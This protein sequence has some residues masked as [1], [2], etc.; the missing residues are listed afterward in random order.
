M[1][2]SEEIKEILLLNKPYLEGRFDVT[3]IGL[4]GSYIRSEQT[5]DSDID[6]LVEFG[7]PIGWEF[8][9]VKEYLEKLLGKNVDLV[10]VKALKPRFKE[11]ILREIIYA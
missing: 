6:I 9:D 10:T 2:N 5:E 11:R 8:I 1:R 7:K 3:K 4:F